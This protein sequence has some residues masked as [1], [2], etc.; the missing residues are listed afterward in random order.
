LILEKAIC[1]ERTTMTR[2]GTSDLDI[3]PLALG[4]NVFGWTADRDRSFALLDAFHAGGGNLLDT[5]DGY[6]AWVEGNGGGVS[7]TLIGEWLASRKPADVLVATK[8]SSHPDFPG[9]S[10]KNVRA[11]AE[12]SLSRLGVSA[13][14]LY[15]A[16]FDDPDTPLEE[17][18]AAF[19]D[20]VRDGLVRHVAVSNY[21]A[22]RIRE[23]IGHAQ[24]GGGPL[25]VAIQPHYNLVERGIETTIV[26]V[27]E[28]FG[29]SVLPYWSLAKGFLT[30]KY[31]S[32]DSAGDGS[33]RAGAASVY[34]TPEG[35]DVIASLER[36]AAAHD[37]S[38]ATT[39]LAWLRQQPTVVAPVASASRVDQIEGLLASARVELTA[40][41]LAELDRVSARVSVDA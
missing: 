5:A 21:T 14:D 4:G 32:A 24:A 12:A 25:P 11:A 16:H 15:Y 35:L 2:I 22:E 7:E 28:E 10:P 31:R 37:V 36:I 41:E 39:S 27:A 40:A 3:F 18:V 20:L 34:A 38:I 6:S 30:G 17:T 29:L 26:P 13:I 23:W 33:P 8:V 1:P 19:A 9:L